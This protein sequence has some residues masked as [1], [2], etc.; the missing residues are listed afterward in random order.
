MST[1]GV[2]QANARAQA[3]GV[4]DRVRFHVSDIATLP[5]PA[6]SVDAAMSVDML[7]FVPDIDAVMAE[8]ARVL[9]PG[10]RFAFTAREQHAAS[11]TFGTSR[12]PGLSPA[13]PRRRL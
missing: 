1:V 3:E 10:A 8:V 2:A 7:V 12:A 4:A 5:L 13:A 6:A 11:A 9:R